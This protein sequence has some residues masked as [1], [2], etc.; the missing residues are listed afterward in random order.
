MFDKWREKVSKKSE[1]FHR[2]ELTAVSY[3]YATLLAQIRQ[4]CQNNTSNQV[5][6][7]ANTYQEKML[8]PIEYFDGG[9]YTKLCFGFDPLTNE[10]EVTASEKPNYIHFANIYNYRTGISDNREKMQAQLNQRCLLFNEI[11]AKSHLYL[12]WYIKDHEISIT[13]RKLN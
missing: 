11:L 1:F 2:Q 6:L 7:K 13:I 3:K 4:L 5:L 10:A 8:H 9:S 12:D